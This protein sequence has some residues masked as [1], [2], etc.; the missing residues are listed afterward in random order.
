M[1]KKTYKAGELIVNEKDFEIE[2]VLTKT[3]KTIKAGDK[4]VVTSKGHIQYITGEAIG[5]RQALGIEVKGYDH[6]SISKRILQRLNDVYGL[7]D[8]IEDE[9]I[10]IY[11]LLDEMEDVLMDIL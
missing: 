10:S 11:E 4:A 9:E 7:E 1:N 2:T 5:M 3:K 6:R 8:F